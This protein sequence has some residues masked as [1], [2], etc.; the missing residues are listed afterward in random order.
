MFHLKDTFDFL[1]L[2]GR[3][4]FVQLTIITPLL[5]AKLQVDILI[6]TTHQCQVSVLHIN[7]TAKA[8]RK[9]NNCIWK[10]RLFLRP[11][12]FA[13]HPF[14]AAPGGVSSLR[15]C[16]A[17]QVCLWCSTGCIDLLLKQRALHLQLH[18][19]PQTISLQSIQKSI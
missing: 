6:L 2:V 12:I 10:N 14:Q 17:S 8:K 16:K 1:T 11:H 15:C 18:P 19:T 13:S 5:A 7:K 3:L 4:K 9:R